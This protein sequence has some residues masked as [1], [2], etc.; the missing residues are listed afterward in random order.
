MKTVEMSSQR[1][2]GVRGFEVF[3]RTC[4][5]IVG[6][7][8]LAVFAGWAFDLPA[9]R[10]IHPA[11][12]S[13]K[14]NS[15]LGFALAAFSLAV[16]SLRRHRPHGLLLAR[17]AAAGVLL[18]GG[19]TLLEHAT[20]WNPGLDQMFFSRVSDAATT[21]HP[22]RMTAPTSALFVAAGARSCAF[23]D[24]MAPGYGQRLRCI[25]TESSRPRSVSTPT[26]GCRTF[27]SF[28]SMPHPERVPLH[29]ARGRDRRPRAGRCSA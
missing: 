15:A 24:P 26:G 18:L 17:V 21:P 25:C 9:L 12:V 16:L 23:L 10:S 22:G 13:M 14:V 11:L 19:A 27:G 7:V 20:G 28:A 4:A 1:R 5:G 2:S 29:G 8:S 6:G 3:S